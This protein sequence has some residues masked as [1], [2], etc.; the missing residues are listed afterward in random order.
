M[1]IEA[2][3]R[4]FASADDVPRQAYTMGIGTIMRARKLLMIISG[5]DK[6]DITA[7]ALCGEVTPQVPASIIQF[8]PD[9]TVIADP[10][11]LSKVKR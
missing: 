6:A 3:K 2:N 8:H 11:A 10:A 4:F 7:A 1:T 9:V 5:E